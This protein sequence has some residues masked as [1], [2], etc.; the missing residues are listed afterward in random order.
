MLV[1]DSQMWMSNYSVGAYLHREVGCCLWRFQCIILERELHPWPV[2][3]EW[4]EPVVT[5]WEK[6]QTL[7]HGRM[8]S[9]ETRATSLK[10]L[11]VCR[12]ALDIRLTGKIPNLIS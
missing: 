1:S 3:K 11:S 8:R 9:T 12:W 6:A 10:V 7:A 2:L 5:R 4:F